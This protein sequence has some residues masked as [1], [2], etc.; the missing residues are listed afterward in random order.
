M[1]T[2]EIKVGS[3]QPRELCEVGIDGEVIL[4][5]Q[6]TEYWLKIPFT[7]EGK[8]PGKEFALKTTVL[9]KIPKTGLPTDRDSA[10]STVLA[11][12]EKRLVTDFS[13]RHR[14]R[15]FGK[16]ELLLD[17]AKPDDMLT[18]DRLERPGVSVEAHPVMYEQLAV[19]ADRMTRT[20]QA[21]EKAKDR[22]FALSSQPSRYDLASLTNEIYAFIGF[23]E[24]CNRASAD[25]FMWAWYQEK[26]PRVRR[27]FD[28]L[29]RRKN[30]SHPGYKHS[31]ESASGA[32]YSFHAPYAYL[33]TPPSP[34]QVEEYLNKDVS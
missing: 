14:W 27:G 8:N 33:E 34:Y 18:E 3:M 13:S 31:A 24:A 20:N 7:I 12:A 26:T 6:A 17:P 23:I 30:T 4:R 9:A 19:D 16:E 29:L 15:T 25:G 10:E 11:L 28:D 32:L 22:L 21:Y 2:L 1:N 5:A